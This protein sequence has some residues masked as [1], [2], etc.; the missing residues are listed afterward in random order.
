M[1]NQVKMEVLTSNGNVITEYHKK[2]NTYIEG[3]KGSEYS[4]R[5]TN[6]T[7][8]KIMCILSVDGLDIVDGKPASHNSRGYILSAYQSTIIDGWRTD[9]ENVRKF[10]FTRE[11][12]SYSKKSGQGTDNL[13]VIGLVAFQEKPWY[14]GAYFNRQ[15]PID[16]W[17]KRSP[18]YGWGTPFIGTLSYNSGE[19]TYSSTMGGSKGSSGG[20]GTLRGGS[21]DNSPQASCEEEVVM[22]CCDTIET[23]AAPIGTGIGEKIESVVHTSSFDRMDVPF[24]TK[25]VYYKERKELERMGV[26]T[27]KKKS[28]VRRPNPFPQ[29]FC[30][31]V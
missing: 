4:I 21:G 6:K 17:P 10:F 7:G 3:R 15:P 9:L 25:T 16:Y 22:A 24:Y 31:E 29:Q 8:Q 18:S 19:A 12:K 26:I 20:G 27:Y 30:K 28:A 23:Q 5:L 11:K 1:Y 2:G 14:G 13:G